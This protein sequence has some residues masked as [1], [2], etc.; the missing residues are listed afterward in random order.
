MTIWRPPSQSELTSM[1]FNTG[2]TPLG[3]E[4]SIYSIYTHELSSQTGITR[5]ARLIIVHP[6]RITLKT[7]NKLFL[8]FRFQLTITFLEFLFFFVSK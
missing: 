1:I 8:T 7:C 5:V 3:S 4:A 6:S 2:L